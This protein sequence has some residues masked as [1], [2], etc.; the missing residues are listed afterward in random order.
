MWE[1]GLQSL[2]RED[3]LEK[4]M[5]ARLWGESRLAQVVCS[6]SLTP[7]FVNKDCVTAEITYSAVHVLPRSPLGQGL[8][9]A[10][11]VR[12]LHLK[13][14]GL[15]TAP[16]RGPWGQPRKRGRGVAAAPAGRGDEGAAPAAPPAPSAPC[17]PRP[18]GQRHRVST[19]HSSMLAWRVPWTQ[20]GCR[21]WSRS[22]RHG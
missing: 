21:P 3:P 8:L 1:T 19:R 7:R 12:E 2:V 15:P 5:A 10:V 9:C 18:Q 20:A 16:W 6:G 13:G 22:I 14:G 4:E 17:P 11:A